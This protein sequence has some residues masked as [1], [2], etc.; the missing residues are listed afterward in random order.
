MRMTIANVPRWRKTL[1]R[2][3]QRSGSAYD[4]SVEP[5]SMQRAQIRLVVANQVAGDAG[6]VLGAKR[7]QLRD[8]HRRPAR[9]SARPAA[10]GREKKPGR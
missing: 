4:R 9:R 6:G 2:K 8:R 1:T 5:V 3:R 10:A 7:R